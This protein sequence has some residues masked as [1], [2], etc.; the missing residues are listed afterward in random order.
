MCQRKHVT[1]KKCPLREC[2]YKEV[3]SACFSRHLRLFHKL[4]KSQCGRVKRIFNMMEPYKWKKEN[5]GPKK[6][7]YHKPK[8]CPVSGCNAT[9][10]KLKRHLT[11]SF[12]AIKEAEEMN[13]L[14][15]RAKRKKTSLGQQIAGKMQ[16]DFDKVESLP[17]SNLDS[18][19]DTKRN[20]WKGQHFGMKGRK[21]I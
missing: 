5:I 9:V 11:V 15:Q 8:K 16:R 17:S 20:I 14:C 19:Y 7:D 12:H 10:I 6:K 4:D 3:N 2:G 18:T 21:A 13:I 1:P